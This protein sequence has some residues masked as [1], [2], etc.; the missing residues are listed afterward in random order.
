MAFTLSNL[1][2][3]TY[4]RLGQWN[5]SIVTGSSNSATVIEDSVLENEGADDDWKGG[6]IF[7]VYDSSGVGTQGEFSRITAYTDS[8]GKFTFDTFSTKAHPKDRYGYVSELYP[9]QSMISLVNTTLQSLGNIPNISTSVTSSANQTEYDIAPVLK[10]NPP[11]RIDLQTNITNSSA[12][13]WEEIPRGHWEFIPS[14]AGSS[15]QI[16]F[17]NYLPTG[18]KLRIW[19][20]DTHPY[21]HVSSN[22][23]HEGWDRELVTL[24]MV[25]KALEWQNSRLQGGDQF[26]LQR[27]NDAKMEAAAARVRFPAWKPKRKSK[28]LSFDGG[29]GDHLPF[30]WP[31]GPGSSA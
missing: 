16:H 21:V 20:D 10:R 17:D 31:Y 29:G 1:L 13:A 8:S 7:L 3:E 27:W 19:Y 14:S 15:A 5:E 23:I 18:R 11:Y 6:T 12:N 28:T 4:K 24:V 30:P 26:L 9:L 25:D 2:Q 22:V